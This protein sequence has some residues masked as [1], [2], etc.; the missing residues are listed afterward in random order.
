MR[1]DGLLFDKDGTLFDFGATWNVW[2]KGV[3]EEFGA[4]DAERVQRLATAMH[5]DLE[6]SAFLP[7]SPVIAGTNREV[8]ELLADCLPGAEAGR[9]EEAGLVLSWQAGQASALDTAE[10]ARGR[11]VGSVRVRDGA[12]R[13]VVHDVMFAFAF[14]AFWPGGVWMLG[15]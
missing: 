14:H 6:K 3:I 11:D 8:A 7:S 2:A 12:G 4:G 1:A 9:I 10:M 5:Y 13:D 15:P